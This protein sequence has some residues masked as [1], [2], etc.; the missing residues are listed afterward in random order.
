MKGK[1]VRNSIM[2]LGLAIIILSMTVI[3]FIVSFNINHMASLAGDNYKDA[4]IE[5]YEEQIKGEVQSMITILQME[6]AKSQDGT[7]TEQEAKKEAAE[8]IRAV[9]YGD[10]G[11][12]YFWIDD[13]DY[14]LVMHPILSEQEGTNRYDLEDQNGVK[15]IQTIMDKVSGEEGGG[16]SEFYFT[17]DDGVTVAPKLAYSQLFEPWGWIVST[18]NYTDTLEAGIQERKGA[19]SAEGNKILLL[20]VLVGAV[21]SVLT[22]IAS[23]IFANALCRPL[24]KIQGLAERLSRGDLTTAVQVRE[25]N[26]LGQTAG[27]LNSAQQQ[28]VGLLSEI[29]NTSDTLEQAV[30]EFTKNFDSM[31][32]AIRNVSVAI[33]EITRNTNM[34]ASATGVASDSIEEIAEEIRNTSEE[35]DSLGNNSK[36]MMEC[37]EKSM[38]TLNQL[39]E[40]NRKTKEDINA[41]Y[42]QTE[43]TNQ[44]VNKISESAVLIS[45]IAAQTNMLSLNAS[46]EAARA[47]E[48]GRGFTVVAEQ[49][50]KLAMQ[51]ADTAN[52]INTI[53]QELADN[54]E[55]SVDIMEKMNDASA[56]QVKALQETQEMFCDLKGA[57]DSC[58]SSIESIIEKIKN[59]NAQKEEVT[60]SIAT[61]RNLAAD[62]AASTEETSAMTIELEGAVEKS[63]DT[64]ESLSNDI[65]KLYQSMKKFKF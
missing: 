52:E 23:R 47:G 65:N 49:I 26:E 46:I 24:V 19:M 36:I 20:V 44:S 31:N 39:I 59:M 11:S 45:Q 56:V 3:S 41:M 32:E 27:T 13:T 42:S 54:S 12:G 34:Q 48:A 33:E 21:M 64:V 25:K 43:S 29:G 60:E 38:G 1:N 50:G 4:V 57:L 14:N 18:G 28:M 15:I 5:G 37:S 51:S 58:V 10:E 61:L 40:I 63:S 16:Y 35:V 55:R 30:E 6:Y 22:I 53:I 2:G 8:F 9:R 7:L 17:K 62:S